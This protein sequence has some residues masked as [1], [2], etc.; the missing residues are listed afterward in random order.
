MIRNN[1][2]LIGTIAKVHGYKGEYLLVAETSI[3]EEIEK[4]ESVFVEIDGLLIPFFISKARITGDSTAIIGFDDIDSKEKAEEFVGCRVFVPRK[5]KELEE[6]E[7]YSSDLLIGY[8][9]IDKKAGVIGSI[10]EILD[11]NQNI[12]FRIGKGD[13]EILIP[14]VDQFIAKVSHK[15]KEITLS[16]PDGLLTINR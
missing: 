7:D 10:E 2:R 13:N 11:L 4:R 16:L 5:G 12:L 8:T 6:E 14:V 9:V 15:K 1:H 3:D